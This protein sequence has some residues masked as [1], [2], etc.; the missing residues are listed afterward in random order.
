MDLFIF[1]T[2]EPATA[3]MAASMPILRAMFQLRSASPK[4]IVEMTEDGRLTSRSTKKSN[5]PEV[6]SL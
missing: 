1:G 5:D 6:V 3:I 2:A 4:R